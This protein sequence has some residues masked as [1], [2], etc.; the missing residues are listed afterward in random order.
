MQGVRRLPHTGNNLLFIL[1]AVVYVALLILFASQT[2]LFINWLFP[3]DQ[4]VMKAL[5]L[6]TFDGMAALWAVGDLFYKFASPGAK[7]I[8]RTAWAISFLLSMLATIFYL[9]LESMLR[10]NIAIT[11]DTVNVGYGV[12]ITAVTLNVLFVTF[13]L[14]L[15]WRA[16]HPEEYEFAQ[17]TQHIWRSDAGQAEEDP[18]PPLPEPRTKPMPALPSPR[19]TEDHPLNIEELANLISVKA[20]ERITAQFE[21]INKRID[22]K[23][24]TPPQ[25]SRKKKTSEGEP[26]RYPA[27]RVEFAKKWVMWERSGFDR[28]KCPW[29]NP[30]EFRRRRPP[31]DLYEQACKALNI[32]VEA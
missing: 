26:G 11:P 13:F 7:T 17:P 22:E 31:Q 3:P 14:Y 10:F 18:F 29:R 1:F 28:D 8:V 4:L 20:N 32:P 19:R 27:A 25:K 12:T 6:L 30:S 15:E 24:T 23:L 2:W 21:A 5:T 16:R 9:V